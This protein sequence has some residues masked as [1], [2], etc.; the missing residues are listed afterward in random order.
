MY[1]R[2][3]RRIRLYENKNVWHD[4][5]DN[6][7]MD[8][9]RT[10]TFNAAHRTNNDDLIV[11]ENVELYGKCNTLHGHEYRLVT[12]VRG[13]L[14]PLHGTVISSEFMDETVEK[15]LEPLRNRVLNEVIRENAT[16][17]N[18]IRYLW[19]QLVD[20]FDNDSSR[21]YRLRL[22]ETERNYFDYYGDQ[23]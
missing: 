6:K 10:Y 2:Q 18:F 1:K 7:F 5:G 23:S 13:T 22:H 8:V 19:E 15:V 17:E 3:V 16:T 12:T 21:L 14:D 11:E 4:V 9:T 20:Q